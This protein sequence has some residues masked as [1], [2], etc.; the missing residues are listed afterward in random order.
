MKNV[1]R[2]NVQNTVSIEASV[3]KGNVRVSVEGDKREE[4]EALTKEY[5][6]KISL[7]LSGENKH[8]FSFI[9]N[10]LAMM[11]PDAPKGGLPPEDV[12]NVAARKRPPKCWI[13][14]AAKESKGGIDETL[15]AI[16][17]SPQW[18]WEDLGESRE[19]F[20]I[21][22]KA[23]SSEA[24]N[25]CTVCHEEMSETAEGH[26]RCPNCPAR[27]CG[28]CYS[29]QNPGKKPQ[30]V[31]PSCFGVVQAYPYHASRETNNNIRFHT[32]TYNNNNKEYLY[33]EKETMTHRRQEKRK[34]MSGKW[35]RKYK[36]CG[37]RDKN[38]A[39]T[40]KKS[41]YFGDMKQMLSHLRDSHGMS[42]LK[43]RFCRNGTW[44]CN[45]GDCLKTPFQTHSDKG[46]D[47]FELNILKHVRKLHDISQVSTKTEIERERII[48]RNPHQNKRQHSNNNHHNIIG[49]MEEEEES[50]FILST[51]ITNSTPPS[52]PTHLHYFGGD[53]YMDKVDYWPI[54]RKLYNNSFL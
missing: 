20:V 6:E 9:S 34:T 23:M 46:K 11:T 10:A 54:K 39:C 52:S 48:R 36:C 7:V 50:I 35:E 4:I 21:A 27:L 43:W 31:C 17:K 25:L 19:E 14:E 38:V 5:L 15:K 24:N 13:I 26:I 51:T 22:S 8:H 1:W 32:P 16:S 28:S 29:I 41:K 49:D 30:Y 2:E 53:V 42:H 37:K 47:A 18:V 45:T 44:T 40:C 33:T 3:C 12:Q